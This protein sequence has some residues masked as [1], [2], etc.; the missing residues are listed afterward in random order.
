[1]SLEPVSGKSGNKH[2]G[3]HWGFFSFLISLVNLRFFLET[4][5][6]PFRTDG[7]QYLSGLKLLYG[8][9]KILMY[10]KSNELKHTTGNHSLLLGGHWGGTSYDKSVPRK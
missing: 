4:D 7:L 9:Q 8:V 3:N 6:W 10:R 5:L 1:M 2:L